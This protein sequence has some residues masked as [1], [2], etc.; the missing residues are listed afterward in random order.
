M[1]PNRT[2][3]LIHQSKELTKAWRELSAA[4]KREVLRECETAEE[5]E[6]ETII[7][8]VVDGQRRLF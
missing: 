8:E 4:Q 5:N 6:I 7:A 3:Y 2:I 1:S